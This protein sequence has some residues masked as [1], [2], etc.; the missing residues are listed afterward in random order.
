RLSGADDPARY[1]DRDV[2]RLERPGIG[3]EL[4]LRPRQD[5]EVARA[6]LAPV[7]PLTDPRRQQL[8]LRAR[9]P[10]APVP[11]LTVGRLEAVPEHPLVLR[12]PRRDDQRREHGLLLRRLRRE[13]T[14]ED[15]VE[16]RLDGRSGAE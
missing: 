4:V 9:D 13:S 11:S 2:P 5:H 12:A 14:R 6:P 16:E 7:D 8:A 10:R 3:R 1:L 15:A